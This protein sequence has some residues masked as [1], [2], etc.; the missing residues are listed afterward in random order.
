MKIPENNL[1]QLY[2]KVQNCWAPSVLV[3]ALFIFCQLKFFMAL[4]LLHIEKKVAEGFEMEASLC[5]RSLWEGRRSW[6]QRENLPHLPKVL[7]TE[8]DTEIFGTFW[9]DWEIYT[10]GGGL[11]CGYLC[12]KQHRNWHCTSVDPWYWVGHLILNTAWV[13]LTID[14]DCNPSMKFIY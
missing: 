12:G 6:H 5:P 9:N 7:Q 11:F 13:S 10:W 8:W 3:L 14:T 2:Q 1:E 4:L